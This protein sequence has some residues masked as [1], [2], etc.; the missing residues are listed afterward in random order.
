MASSAAITALVLVGDHTGHP[1]P[2][3]VVVAITALGLGAR[4]AT[5]A[6]RKRPSAVV[7]G[8]S[9]L[10]A[11]ALAGEALNAPAL[12]VGSALVAGTFPLLDRVLDSIPD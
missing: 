12:Q 8:T 11:L 10:I 7:G 2:W 5:E 9:A 1:V 4:G 6:L 3:Y